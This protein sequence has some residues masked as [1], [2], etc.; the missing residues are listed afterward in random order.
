MRIPDDIWRLIFKW[1]SSLIRRRMINH[2]SNLGPIPDSLLITGNKGAGKTTLI[3]NLLY[4]YKNYFHD[5]YVFS[6]TVLSDVSLV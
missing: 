4:Y 1:N 2:F 5:I 3:G 6:P